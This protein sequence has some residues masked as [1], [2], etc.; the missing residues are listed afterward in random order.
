MVRGHHSLLWLEGTAFERSGYV[1][2][3]HEI[4]LRY[5]P[6][7]KSHEIGSGGVVRCGV[8]SGGDG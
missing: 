4:L 2:K 6:G 3:S 8:G 5:V 1:Q 7:H